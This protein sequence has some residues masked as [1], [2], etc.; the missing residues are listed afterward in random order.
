MSCMDST[1]RIPV[2]A[3]RATVELIATAPWDE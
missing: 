2:A 1:P 3:R